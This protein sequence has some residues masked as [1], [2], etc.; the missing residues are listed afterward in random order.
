[1]SVSLQYLRIIINSFFL[2]KLQLTKSWKM[3][4]HKSCSLLYRLRGYSSGFDILYQGSDQNRTS[5]RNCERT[6]VQI[7]LVRPDTK[8]KKK[9]EHQSSRWRESSRTLILSLMYFFSKTA[10]RKLIK[11]CMN[12]GYLCNNT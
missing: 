1:M 5:Y 7:Y 4:R 2:N 10:E 9:F 8:Y 6:D 12:N 11:F 3:S